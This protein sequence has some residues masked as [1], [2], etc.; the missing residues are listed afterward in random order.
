MRCSN[1][2]TVGFQPDGKTLSWSQKNSSKEYATFQL[3]CG[4]CLACRLEYARQWAVRCIHEA[5]MHPK[6]SFITLTYDDEHLRSPKLIYED[7]Q[8]FMK[9]LRTHIN[10]HERGYQTL[11]ETQIGYFVTG[12]YGDK[13]KRPH[14]HALIFNWRP[15]DLVHKYTNERGDHVFSS[16]TLSALWPAGIAELGSV[17]F[18]SAGY[19]ARYAAKKLVHG[20]DSEH[21]YRPISKKSSRQ[22]IGKKFLEQHYESI[23][24]LGF[25][26]LPNGKQCSI[27]RYYEKWLK[28][29]HPDLWLRYVTNKK[30]ELTN[31]AKEKNEKQTALEKEI[32]E[33]RRPFTPP[34]RSRQ[35]AKKKILAAK[36]KQLQKYQ[37]DT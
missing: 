2:R 24:N 19:C 12:E 28:K 14:W 30:L 20:R 31:K 11:E 9:R 3:P 33:N 7:F 18:E 15:T 34:R 16:K 37:K 25:I 4:Q 36:F 6:N 17:T 13:R 23:F 29:N 1:P 32:N 21:D 22:A 35:E 27:P 10:D 8:D 26:N 5:E